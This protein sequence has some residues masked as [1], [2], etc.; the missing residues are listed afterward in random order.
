MKWCWILSKAV[1]ESIEKIM[2]FLYLILLICYI[3]FNDLCVLNHPWIPGMKPTWPWCMI[4][5]ICCCVQFASIS[6]KIFASLFTKEI[7]L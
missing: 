4:F 1:S 7:G 2:W 5:L 6:L 3:T